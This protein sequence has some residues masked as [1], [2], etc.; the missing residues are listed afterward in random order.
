MSTQTASASAPRRPSHYAERADVGDE[1]WLED[2]IEDYLGLEVTEAQRQICRSVA[3]NRRTLVITANGLGK[4]YIL[5]AIAVIWLVVRY[6]AVSFATSGTEK[7]MRR[8]FCKP[9]ENLHDNAVVPLPGEYKS[10]PERIEIEGEPEHFFEA[11]SPKDADELE[12]VH[13]AYTLAIIEEADKPAVDQDI[14]D[15]MRSLVTDEQDRMVAIANPPKDETNSI[16]AL[17]DS[18]KWDVHRFSSFDSHNVQVE[19]GEVDGEKIDGLA[20]LTKIRDDWEEYHDEAWPGVDAARQSG[21]RDD[22]DERWYR[23]RLGEMPPEGAAQN[24]PFG[25]DLVEAAY[26]DSETLSVGPRRGAGIDVAREGDRTTMLTECLNALQVEYS[27]P[28]TNHTEQFDELWSMLDD[29]PNIP[30]SVDAIGEGSG[31]ADDTAARYDD[32]ER[33]KAGEEAA[34]STEYKNRWTEGLC[35]LGAWM[36]RGGQFSDR[37]LYEE[38]AAAAREITLEEKYYSSRDDEVYVADPKEKIKDRLGRSPDHLDAAMQA[39]LAA[40]GIQP[41]DDGPSGSGTW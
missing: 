29:T 20:T 16:K 18:P 23:R 33:F 15:S 40:E 39:V 34:Q 8:T 13:A 2:A 37:R 22:L 36:E 28:G 5:A 9:V 41:E 4:S 27:E 3:S 17:I 14:L 25:L 31:K 10:R 1:T 35:E 38:L 7:K 24:R 6:P 32:V 21:H 19:L 11:A 30:I 12:G 26:V